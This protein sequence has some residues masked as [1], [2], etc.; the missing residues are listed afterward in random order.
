MAFGMGA[1]AKGK[2]DSGGRDDRSHHYRRL[3]STAG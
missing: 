3:S 1:A 2:Y